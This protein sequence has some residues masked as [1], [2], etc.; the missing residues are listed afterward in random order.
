MEEN[1]NQQ[2]SEFNM[3]LAVLQRIDSIL[4]K[5]VETKISKDD[6]GF[7]WSIRVLSLLRE[8]KNQVYYDLDKDDKK[9]IDDLFSEGRK[10]VDT[11]INSKG[12]EK[13][14]E[15]EDCFDSIEQELRIF[16]DNRKMLIK[17][18]KDMGKNISMS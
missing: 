2:E 15:L 8:L 9:K 11:Y 5:L 12:K 10:F 3:A 14:F 7:D 17:H 16:L 4:N 1:N 18:K 6:F 13:F